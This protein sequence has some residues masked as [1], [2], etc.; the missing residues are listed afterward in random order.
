MKPLLFDVKSLLKN[1]IHIKE[2]HTERLSDQLHFHNAYEIALIL[3]G[4]G[5]RIVGDS[6]DNFTDGDLT[7]I[8]PNL[9][10]A[11]YSDEKFHIR[12]N[13]T[14]IQGI[15]V[16]FEPDWIADK[17]LITTDFA[18]I[19]ALF[20]QFKQGIKLKGRLSTKV[21]DLL[22]Q[23]KNTEGIASFIIL[24]QIL[25]AIS[26]S[27]EY[28]CLSSP[29]YANA[30]DEHSIKKI[31]EIYKYVMENFT[32]KISLDEVASIAHM[33]PP[34]FCKYFKSKTNKTFTN[35]VNEIRVG[36]ACEI[37]LNED[38]DISQVSF[39]CGFNNFTSFNRNFKY[40]TKKTP[41]EY[42]LGLLKFR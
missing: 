11:N 42:R 19:K 38:L 4:N 41:S 17:H 1:S 13:N 20:N 8:G 24:F 12:E 18:P 14:I 31:H 6:V 22:V 33:T 5:R 15:V 32:K 16:Y 34:A 27:E 29:G 2:V 37:L 28:V 39:Q 21:T 26:L 40:Y 9:P 30:Y 10:H 23:I 36:Y 25:H 3:K 7:I 35:F